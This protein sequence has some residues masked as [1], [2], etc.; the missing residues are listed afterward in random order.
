MSRPRRS[1]PGLSQTA[2]EP[3]IYRK[4]KNSRIF[5][6]NSTL[7]QNLVKRKALAVPASKRG[8]VL[9]GMKAIAKVLEMEG[10]L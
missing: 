9:E 5:N 10:H 7:C 8:L 2:L 1:T 4:C 6:Y 3:T